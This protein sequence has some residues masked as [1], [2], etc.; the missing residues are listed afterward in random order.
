V[1]ER[2][3]GGLGRLRGGLARRG[4]V[5]PYRGQLIAGVLAGLSRRFGVSVAGLRIVFLVSMLFPGPQFLLYLLLWLLMP[6]EA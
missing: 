4:Y 5:R 2:G 6:R 3:A 1:R